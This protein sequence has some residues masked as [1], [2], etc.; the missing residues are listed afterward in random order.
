M[1][2]MRF[3]GGLIFI[4]CASQ[5]HGATIAH[6]EVQAG[7]NNKSTVET[8]IITVDGEKV[9]VHYL[10]KEQERTDIT[11]YWPA[12]RKAIADR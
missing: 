7:K 10:G 1:N 2:T 8:N 11:P 9:R 3:L 6:M 5:V 4:V 12:Y